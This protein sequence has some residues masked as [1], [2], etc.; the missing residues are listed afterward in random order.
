M[1]ECSGTD[2]AAGGQEGVEVA[3]RMAIRALDRQARGLADQ[4]RE[5]WEVARMAADYVDGASTYTAI[6]LSRP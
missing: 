5:Y 3:H 6:S 4:G 2:E 1:R